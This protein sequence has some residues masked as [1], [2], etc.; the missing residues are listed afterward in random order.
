M[1]L[2]AGLIALNNASG[3]L[4]VLILG[5]SG[6]GKSDLALRC[7]ADGFQLVADDRTLV[8]RSGVRIWGRAPDALRGLIEARSIGVLAR[9]HR[10]FAPVSLVV[11]CL[12]RPEDAERLPEPGTY[13]VLDQKLPRCALWPFEHSAPVKIRALLE[14]LGAPTQQAY[15][16]SPEATG[17][18]AGAWGTIALRPYA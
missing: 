9:P 12:D 14:R 8:F 5:R 11:Q 16:T 2:H 6:A 15:Q 7:M 18:N 13:T 10:P 3:W 17:R 4:G 1:I